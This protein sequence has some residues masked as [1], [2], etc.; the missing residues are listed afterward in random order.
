MCLLS[1][2]LLGATSSRRLESKVSRTT[3]TKSQSWAGGE[4]RGGGARS[5]AQPVCTRSGGTLRS[6]KVRFWTLTKGAAPAAPLLSTA[7]RWPRVATDGRATRRMALRR[8][9]AGWS[10]RIPGVDMPGSTSIGSSRSAETLGGLGRVSRAR[11]GCRRIWQAAAR[12]DSMQ[13]RDQIQLSADGGSAASVLPS[14]WAA[15]AAAPLESGFIMVP[16]TMSA[17]VRVWVVSY[18]AV[19]VVRS[20]V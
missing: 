6:L 19:S 2:P 14:C 17:R 16:G 18:C 13:I 10:F 12:G 9:T 11:A 4:E 15:A 5:L 20:V 1:M 7:R 3:L 8:T